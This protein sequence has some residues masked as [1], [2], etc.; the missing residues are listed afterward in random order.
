MSH[1][2][3]TPMNAILGYA[4]MLAEDAEEAGND[5]QLADIKE[6]MD[7]GE[8][9]LS[10]LNDVLDISKV[11][12]G[13]MDLYLETF[14]LAQM[15]N[16]VASTTRALIDKNKNTMEVSITDDLGD[17]HADVT[18]VRQILF[19]LMS[20]AA[21]FT[22]DG[23]IT[24]FG[25]RRTGEN[26]DIIRL[27][28]SDDGIGI[29]E[30]KL[31]HIFEE[32]SQ[33]DDTT[34]KN[35]GGTGLGLALVRK[36]CQMMG[37]EIWVE[38][39][40]SEGSSFI[41]ELPAVVIDLEAEEGE[42]VKTQKDISVS[43]ADNINISNGGTILVIDD[44][45]SA[46]DLIKRSLES[47][48]HNVTVA[49]DGDEGIALARSI[50]P[51][52]ITL[53]IMM[54]GRDGW[55]VLQELKD[56]PELSGIPVIMVSMIDD[57]KM[58]RALGA[59]DHMT[60]PV[61]RNKLKALV[62]RY[63]KKGRALVVED[64]DAAR[65]VVARA[66]A[67][68]GWTSVEAENGAVGIEKFGDG[69]FDLIILDIMMPVMDGFGF[70]RELRKTEKGRSVPVVVLTAKDLTKEER[71]ELNGNVEEIF[72]KEETS[73]DDLVKEIGNQLAG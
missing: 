21:K 31:D 34:T 52:L 40:V 37:G 67:S 6:I 59:I 54:P 62:K 35:F 18:K 65:E 11:E 53:D 32:F 50:K 1:E 26:G 57:K 39:T 13:R 22:S 41:F 68:I 64:D 46:R 29:P 20:N 49:E 24:L 63:S 9:L 25:E 36:F 51:S 10:L 42:G 15:M 17:M 47:E 61:D 2:L 66:L 23:K 30:D 27:G 19:N 14:D 69:K 60:K 43:T 28:V 56:D 33:A 4:E 38:S 55:S 16:E 58:G 8:H 71:K 3:R 70:I 44:D 72:L 12:A 48:G 73:V 5:D 45:R 7:S